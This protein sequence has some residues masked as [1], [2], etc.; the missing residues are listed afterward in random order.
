MSNYVTAVGLD[1]HTR[2]I[3]ARAFDPPLIDL[4]WQLRR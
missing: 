2:S 4:D 3:S 1:V